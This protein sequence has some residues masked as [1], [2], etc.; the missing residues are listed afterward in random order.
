MD[1]G[2]GRQKKEDTATILILSAT[3]RFYFSAFLCW[4]VEKVSRKIGKVTQYTYVSN[5]AAAAAEEEEMDISMQYGSRTNDRTKMLSER[6]TEERTFYYPHELL[7]CATMM[8]KQPNVN[9]MKIYILAFYT[10]RVCVF[11]RKK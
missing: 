10:E 2:R 5:K 4:H 1:G 3:V 7:T 11:A 9:K 8:I 6:K